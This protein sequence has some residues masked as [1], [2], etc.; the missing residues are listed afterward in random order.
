[1]S[2]SGPDA[3]RSLDD[4]LRDVRREEDEVSRR[5]ARSAE[6]IAKF[7]ET[8]SELLRE[9]AKVRLDP[10]VQA[11]LAGQLTAA[12]ARARDMLAD[13]DKALDA[14]GVEL[15]AVDAELADIAARRS[16]AVARLEM[17]RAELD[18]LA[19]RVEAECLKDA[20]YL[21]LKAERDS[22]QAVA[23]KSRSKTELAER[24]E[25]Q[26]GQPYRADPLFMYLWERNWGT[27]QYKGKGLSATL[28]AWVARQ[29]GYH[30][31][32]A[33]FALLNNIPLRLKAHAERQQQAADA[34]SDAL[35]EMESRALEVAG[36]A[37][38][39]Q[40]LEAASE[41]IA[42]IEARVVALEDKRDSLVK[43]QRDLAQGS[44]PTFTDAIAG[45]AA[46]LAREDIRVLLSQARATRTGR[47]DTIVQQIEEVRK[48]S[49][50][51][52]ADS[53]DQK[54]RLKTLAARRRELEDIQYE[55]RR[56]GFDNPRSTFREDNLVG[57]MLN[58]FLRGGISA[59]DYWG[60]WRNSQSWSG[61]RRDQ[62]FEWPDSSFGGGSG[63]RRGGFGG[64]MGLPPLGGP[65]GGQSGGNSGGGTFSR[66]REGTRGKRG[67]D[68]FKTG[69]GF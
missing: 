14:A 62:G 17:T 38:M 12:E 35:E 32:R 3:L 53:R 52:K 42:Q 57:D 7:Q 50:E 16:G 44:D 15:R 45:L 18:T 26:K 23:D 54:A 9:L 47:D 58:E 31:A 27:P 6:L 13:H 63:R 67:S 48:R 65:W 34:A 5:V 1:M 41:A 29:V 24:D 40:K 37:P 49:M 64:N 4:A 66:P 30:E 68:S 8:E 11:E 36:A 69:G 55:F 25:A 33:N 61:G 10:A 51:E 56:Q 43:A 19:K 46:V 21:A 60:R 20:S 28:D 22:L 39:R 2:L 59:A